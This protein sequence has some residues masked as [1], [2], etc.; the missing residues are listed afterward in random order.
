MFSD[1]ITQFFC[2]LVES[3]ELSYELLSQSDRI[4]NVFKG[5]FHSLQVELKL[6]LHIRSCRC[7]YTQNKQTCNH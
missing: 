7:I 3:A 4:L 5:F 6:N 1:E 2:L